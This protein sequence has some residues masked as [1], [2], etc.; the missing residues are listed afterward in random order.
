MIDWV[1]DLAL[2]WGAYLRTLGNPYSSQNVLDMLPCGVQPRSLSLADI[3]RDD[4]EPEVLSFHRAYLRLDELH[5]TVV[6]VMYVPVAS[7]QQRMAALKQITGLGKSK[8]YEV[9]NQSHSQIWGYI[10]AHLQHVDSG[11]LV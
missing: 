5:R 1:H 11:N 8:I 10:D 6:Y 3:D 9:R 2:E 7:T 4:S